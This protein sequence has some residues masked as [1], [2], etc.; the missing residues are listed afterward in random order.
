MSS[1][2]SF[3][4]CIESTLAGEA[5]EIYSLNK[6]EQAFPGVGALPYSLKI[7]LENLLRHE[8]A[9]YGEWRNTPRW[10]SRNS[11]RRS[12]SCSTLAT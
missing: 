10:P 6:L 7:L 8:D 2:N 5:V 12:Y 9:R 3:G 4:T 11:T 1:A